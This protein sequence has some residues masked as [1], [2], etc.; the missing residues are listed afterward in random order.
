MSIN[1]D[2]LDCIDPGAELTSIRAGLE[3]LLAD[4]EGITRDFSPGAIYRRAERATRASLPKVRRWKARALGLNP[5][6]LHNAIA[7]SGMVPIMF[8]ERWHLA[9]ALPQPAPLGGLFD[10][11]EDVVLIDPKSGNAHVMGDR[12]AT[13]IAP[14]A[15]LERITVTTDAHAWA[16]DIALARLEWFNLRRSRQRA[17]QAIPSWTGDI[18]SALILASPKQV[19]WADF[20]AKII[21]VPADMRRDVRHAIFAQARIP[22]VEGRA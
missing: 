16:R 20:N 13:H 22:K 5:T 9:V 21:D 10:Q 8:D 3:K 7:L 1:T 11:I 15:S 2:L 6:P 14:R 19:R 4:C 18:P 12:G 17:M